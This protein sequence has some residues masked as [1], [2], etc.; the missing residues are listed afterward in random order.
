MSNSAKPSL[1]SLRHRRAIILSLS[2]AAM[3]YLAVVML[4]G[5]KDTWQIFTRLG[6][7]GWC[8]LLSCSFCSYLLRFVRWQYFLRRVDRRLPSRLH[9]AYYLAGFALTTTPG[10]AGETIRSVLLRPH[11]VPYPTSLASFNLL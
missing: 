11:G 7:G 3:L 8:I 4:T 9:L 1:F 2:L 10:K 6:L 5:T